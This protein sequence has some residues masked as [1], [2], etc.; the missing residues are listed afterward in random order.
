MADATPLSRDLNS[1]RIGEVSYNGVRF[2][3]AI[4][5][6][7]RF[8]PVYD[9]SNRIMK[10][11]QGTLVIECYMFPGCLDAPEAI[12]GGTG[13]NVYRLPYNNAATPISGGIGVT[14]LSGQDVTTG[15]TL[16]TIRKRLMEPCQRL[17]FTSQGSG[18][19]ILNGLN[20]P[21][22]V[23][24]GPRPKELKWIPLTN[25]MAKI[26]WEVDF[27]FCPCATATGQMRSDVAQFPFEVN[28][29]VNEAGLTVRTITGVYEI[30]LTRVPT[31]TANYTT[32]QG[33][34]ANTD[35]NG[36]AGASRPFN[37]VGA[38][39]EI[40]SIFPLLKQFKRTTQE[41]SLS[42]DRKTINFIIVD[43]EIN[44]EE[45]FGP[46]IVDE[47]V[48]LSVSSSLTDGAFRKWNVSLNGTIEM[49]AGYPK[50]VGYIEIARLFDRYYNE[51]SQKGF[52]SKYLS[53]T[54]WDNS[55][56]PRTGTLKSFPILRNVR[57]DDQIF[58]RT[59]GFQYDWDLFVDPF[60]IFESTGL[61]QPF[62]KS[63]AA[64]TNRWDEWVVSMANVLDKGSYQEL[65]MTQNDDVVVSLC[66]PW[67]GPQRKFTQP[68]KPLKE[69]KEKDKKQQPEGANTDS[70][71]R[72]TESHLYSDY[73][74]HFQIDSYSHTMTHTPLFA[75]P[76]QKETADPSLKNKTGAVPY[77]RKDS[78]FSEGQ[79]Q[80]NTYSVINHKIRPTTYVL[81]MMGY[82]VRL[83]HPPR[84]PS[85]QSVGG[86][87]VT[88]IGCDEIR[89]FIVGSG[90]DVSTGRDYSIHGLMWKKQ[91]ALPSV[92]PNSRVVSD[93][94]TPIYV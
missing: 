74:C 16:E 56:V 24:N 42:S 1:H 8:R 39:Q 36:A 80:N 76:P 53:T 11:V 43:T 28:I 67:I 81:T 41:F 69:P 31:R 70:T 37:M 20:T 84:V 44:S 2:P 6:K 57:F 47:D 10:Y 38:E 86:L 63:N 65:N 15:T 62:T 58:S 51:L 3:P 4:S 9:E 90:I 7:A 92:P 72:S 30:P 52:S 73:D 78:G 93:G 59:L 45:A 55:Q 71:D 22:D 12:V 32:P 66:I 85:V 54:G 75:S 87:A 46:G 94:H 26:A 60:Y 35:S 17:A 13:T 40:I 19:V 61:F 34:A 79:E 21:I 64:R 88:K 25:K 29:S 23:D 18:N 82:A 49:M 68:K 89:P 77:Y 27:S 50:S 48:K 83:G 91:Y 5:S 14:T 33:D